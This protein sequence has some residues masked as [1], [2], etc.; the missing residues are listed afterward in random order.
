MRLLIVLALIYILYR[1]LKSSVFSN[2]SAD[3]K[4]FNKMPGEIDDIMVKDPY[5][6]TYFPKRDG[7]HLKID[8]KNLY[9]CSKECRDKFIESQ[10]NNF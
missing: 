8:G 6:S 7:V 2:T 9:F 5:C 4:S 10:K 3:G 1:A